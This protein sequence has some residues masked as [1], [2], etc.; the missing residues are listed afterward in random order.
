MM[1]RPLVGD[2]LDNRYLL[3]DNIGPSRISR[4]YLALDTALDN[5]QVA[6]RHVTANPD[7]DALQTES[8]MLERLHHPNLPKVID[9]ITDQRFG[10]FFVIQYIRG[11]DL[12]LRL[13]QQHSP[14][15]VDTVLVWADDLLNALDY[16]HQQ[17]PLIIHANICPRN[18]KQ[19]PDGHIV[20]VEPAFA[21]HNDTN[22]HPTNT[23]RPPNSTSI[24]APLEQRFSTI[25]LSPQ[26]DIYAL[27]ATLYHLLTAT[28]PPDAATRQMA[29]AAGDSDPL[30]PAH[31]LTDSVVPERL[32]YVLH[33]AMALSPERRYASAADMRHALQQVRQPQHVRIVG[34]TSDAA[35]QT[36]QA[37]LHDATPE[38][39]IL[40]EPGTYQESIVIE[41]P[42]TI[43]GQQNQGDVIIQSTDWPLHHRESCQCAT[44]PG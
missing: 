44:S 31:L 25:P 20:L 19:H 43:I 32:A 37:A 6:L 42:V 18:L 8:S 12:E 26:S 27:G 35:Y 7:S 13:H 14:F 9:L 16:L 15:P 5:A 21:T 36:I 33:K 24:Y 11:D 39:V 22:N 38:T 10:A 17:T 30:R 41:Q 23:M 4:V 2:I 3:T 29:L 34:Q 28:E 40:I 1:H